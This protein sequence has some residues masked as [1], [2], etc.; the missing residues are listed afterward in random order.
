MLRVLPGTF[1]RMLIFF[2]NMQETTRLI[3]ILNH[4]LVNYIMQT[5]INKYHKKGLYHHTKIF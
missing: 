4:I 5:L 1:M 3:D 2:L